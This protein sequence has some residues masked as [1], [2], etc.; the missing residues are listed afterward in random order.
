MHARF[1][2]LKVRFFSHQ[3]LI[4]KVFNVWVIFGIKKLKSRSMLTE[5]GRLEW[6]IY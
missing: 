3:T 4:I 5:T 6:T 2:T 1:A